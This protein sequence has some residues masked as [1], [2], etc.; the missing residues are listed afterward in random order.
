MGVLDV[1]GI[2]VAGSIQPLTINDLSTLELF[3]WGGGDDNVPKMKIR[4]AL[5]EV[6]PS[7]ACY[8]N[9]ATGSVATIEGSQ[10]VLRVDGAL[11]LSMPKV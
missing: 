1:K 10:P 4:S 2:E 8:L 9:F 5:L 7:L 3:F 6:E 11:K